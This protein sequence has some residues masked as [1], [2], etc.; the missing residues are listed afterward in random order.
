MIAVTNIAGMRRPSGHAPVCLEVMIPARNEAHNLELAIPPLILGGSFVTVFDDE[1]TDGTGEVAERLG[2]KVIHPEGPLPPGW[3]G[4]N[5]ATHELSVV[6]VAEWVVFL[7]ADTIPCPEF[8]GRLSAFLASRP[9]RVR[10]VSGFPRMLP[11]RGIEPAYLSWVPWILLAANPFGLVARTGWGHGRFTNGQFAAWRLDTLREVRPFEALRGE[12]LEDVKIGRMLA[13]RRI[14]VEIANLSGILSVRMYWN[15]REAIDGMSKNSG[16]I[17]GSALGSIVFALALLV[18]GWAW[19]LGGAMAWI[20]LGMLMASK[21]ITDRTVRGPWW[22][23]PFIPL[24]VLAAALTVFRSLVWI[25]KK[26]VHWKGR[27][28]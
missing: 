21:F 8:V 16:H 6:A 1:S 23:F 25:R 10:V 27:V 14:R 19:V 5:R 18:L 7:D 9:E 17:G 13:K 22:T 26:Q 28:Y 15:L 24:T 2:A 20:L 4:K 3:T 12:V 11:G